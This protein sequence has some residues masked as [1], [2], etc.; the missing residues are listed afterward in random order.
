MGGESSIPATTSAAAL[1][2]SLHLRYFSLL[3]RNP[4]F[5]RL[6]LAQLISELG[7]WF[8]SLAVYDL[9]LNKTHSGGAVGW[10][11]IIQTLPW[12]FMTPLA[13]YIADRFPRRTLMILADI[14][15]GLIVLGLLFPSVASNVHMIYLLLG[16]EVIFAS[17]FEPARS[18]ILPN[19]V[20]AEE[21]LP[22][23]ALSSATWSFALTVGAA[24][25]GAMTALLGR[26][27]AFVANSASFF[28][29][30]ILIYR[31]S[32]HEQ[33]LAPSRKIAQGI[34]GA[35][36]SIREG[37]EYVKTNGK[38]LTLLLA[39][40]GVGIL[41]GSLLLLVIFGERI[42]PLEGR[43]ALAVGLLYAAR[44][45]GAGVGPLIGDRL[46]N[47]IQSRMWKSIGISFFIIG[48]AYVAFSHA[49][50]LWLAIFWIFVGHM[51][52]SNIWVMSTTLLQLNTSD[53][54]RGRVFSLDFGLFMLMIAVSNY[55]VGQGL[56][57]WGFTA[58]ELAADLGLLMVIPGIL[59]IGT[60]KFWGAEAV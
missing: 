6:W 50:N 35:T 59:W 19:V 43:G 40:A 57:T 54:V 20:S 14:F 2:A 41:G 7:D 3:R 10:A 12:F 47:N 26:N 39:K 49:S 23:N 27:V 29:S 51:G 9:L 8:Y 33:H 28:A 30:A 32:V 5:R 56:D 1:P 52:G 58:R 24:L 21:I 17:I 45:V 11:I 25:G 16:L 36:A 46:T 34:A 38:V 60:R 55:L 4:N 13:G 44:G 37:L 22:A 15:Q 53:Q 18:A 48:A 42:F 31:I